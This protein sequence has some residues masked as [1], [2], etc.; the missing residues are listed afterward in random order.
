MARWLCSFFASDASGGLSMCLDARS[1]GT[2]AATGRAR[3]AAREGGSEARGERAQ[4]ER[5]RARERERA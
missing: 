1:D 2:R 4:T 5:E 3:V